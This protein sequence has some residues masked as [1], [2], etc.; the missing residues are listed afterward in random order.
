LGFLKKNSARRPR[1]SRQVEIEIDS[2]LGI[3]QAPETRGPQS[4]F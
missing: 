3:D 1:Q 2:H 4:T